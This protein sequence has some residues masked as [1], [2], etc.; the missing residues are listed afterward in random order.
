MMSWGSAFQTK[1]LGTSR[2]QA[3]WRRQVILAQVPFA[4]EED[5]LELADIVASARRNVS[6]QA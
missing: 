3:F 4:D 2:C 6:E 1:G 5:T